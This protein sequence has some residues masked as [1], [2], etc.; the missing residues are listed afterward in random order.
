MIYPLAGTAFPSIACRLATV[1]SRMLQRL[2]SLD[3]E[4]YPGCGL[5]SRTELEEMDSRFVAAVELAFANG[6]E[7]RA[8]LQQLTLDRVGVRLVRGFE[9]LAVAPLLFGGG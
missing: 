5:W 6:L 4:L 3:E 7:S 9:P 8:L 1:D 2:Q